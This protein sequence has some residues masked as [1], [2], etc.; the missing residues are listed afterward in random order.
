MPCHARPV[1]DAFDARVVPSGHVV[2]ALNRRKFLHTSAM[3]LGSAALGSRQTTRSDDSSEFDVIVIGA[4]SSGCVVANRLTADP[5]LRVLLLEAGGPPLP[6]AANPGT[7]T[8]LLGGP[9]DWKYVTEPDPKLGGRSVE[10]PR[11]RAYGGSGAISALAYMR[12]HQLSFDGWARVAGASWSY[13]DVLPLFRRSERNSRGASAYHGGDGPWVVT[14]TTDPHAGHLAFLEAARELG[15]S[16]SPE[17]DFDGPRQENGAGFYQ[18]NLY[19]GRRHT[20]ADAFLTPALTRSN[21]VV[22]P[23]ALVTRLLWSGRRVTGVEFVRAGRVERA[24][25]RREVIVSAGTIATPKLLML[26]GVGPADHLRAHGIAIVAD[27]PAVG[28]NL[29]D[30]PRVSVRWAGRQP[31]PGSMVSAGLLTGSRSRSTPS[32]PDLQFYVGRGLSVADPAVTITVAMTQPES[33]GSVRLR[34]ADP[35]AAPVIDARYFDAPGDLDALVEGVRLARALVATR[36]YAPLAGAPAAGGETSAALRAFILATSATMFHPVGTCRMGE[37][38]SS[39]V[40][41]QLRVR[42]VDGLRIADGSIMP[43]VV[44]A[45]TNAACVMIGERAAD[46]VRGR[47]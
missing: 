34:S 4:G 28:T 19:H 44:N 11:G 39:V 12:G 25:A 46:L 16:A 23:H 41:P 2:P 38:A 32:P 36:A 14:S 8:S 27:S 24:R 15:F 5:G 30:H 29:Q 45:Q 31:L 18:K 42:G 9:M 26:S 22:T 21:L 35:R 47:S 33:R 3:V 17:W 20:V 37:D 43:T 13:R 7:W 1:L 40:D 10:W 6:A